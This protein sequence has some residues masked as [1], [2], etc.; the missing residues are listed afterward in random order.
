MQRIYFHFAKWI[1]SQASFLAEKMNL[2]ESIEQI[3][4]MCP[5]FTYDEI[6]SDLS[7]T[8]DVELTVK[9]LLDK[10]ITNVGTQ[11]EL[12]CYSCVVSNLSLFILNYKS[13]NRVD[14]QHGQPRFS[15]QNWFKSYIFNGL[16]SGVF[17]GRISQSFTS[18]EVYIFFIYCNL[19]LYSIIT[20]DH[21]VIAITFLQVKLILHMID[22]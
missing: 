18:H 4:S 13:V 15:A 20:N 17:N 3:S 12:L 10:S 19:R 5:S 9:R 11:V 7:V 14:L 6:K 2:D 16:P 21:A 1:G 8:N 22:I